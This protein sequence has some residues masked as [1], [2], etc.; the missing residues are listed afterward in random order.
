MCYW[1]CFIYLRS[2]D[3]I[4]E[5]LGYDTRMYEVFRPENGKPIFS[6]RFRFV[7]ILLCLLYVCSFLD[8]EK[9][10]KGWVNFGVKR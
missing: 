10:G 3:R 8:Y 7:A 6:T 4:P 9:K 1:N 2:I 5:I